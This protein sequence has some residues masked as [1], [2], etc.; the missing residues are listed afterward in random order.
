M[1]EMGMDM[2]TEC[3]QALT[4][5]NYLDPREAVFATT[6][7]GLLSLQLGDRFY[8]KVD[9]Y[10][11]FPFSLEYQYISVRDD[12]GDEI[13]IIKDLKE[14]PPQSQEAIRKELSWRYYAPQITRILDLKDEFG[15]LYWDVETNYGFRK[16]V[17]RARDEGIYPI[18]GGR[19]L[20]VD[21]AGNRYVIEDSRRLDAKSLR[22]LEPYI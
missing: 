15:H 3:L 12:K 1:K 22:F 4:N 19:L 16:F 11:A 9:L 10:Q 17:T 13:G 21:M 18:A 7:G 6:E 5:I 8:S 20:I 2:E 14:F